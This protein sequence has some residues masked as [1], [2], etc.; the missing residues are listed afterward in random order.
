M[1]NTGQSFNRLVGR[2]F[3]AITAAAK[4]AKAPARR[5][6]TQPVKSL[7]GWYDGSGPKQGGTEMVTKRNSVS[8]VMLACLLAM[9][10][11]SLAQSPPAHPATDTSSLPE[12]GAARSALLRHLLGGLNEILLEPTEDRPPTMTDPLRLDEAVAL[13]LQNNFEIQAARARTEASEW[14]VVG[15]YGSYLPTVTYTRSNGKERSSPA[16][17]TE[18]SKR[19]EDSR[20]HRWDRSV[21]IVQPVIDLTLISDIL[22]RH[23]KLS[24]SELE[25]LGV[26][27]RVALQTAT[28]FLKI[29]RAD[30]SIRYA[31]D[32]KNHLDKLTT[33]MSNRV[34]G[35][36]AAGAD[37]D[38]VKSRATSAQAALIETRSDYDSALD[39]FR[40]LSGVV[41]LKLQMPAAL[42]PSV[43]E[44]MQDAMTRTLRSNPDYLL[45][46]QQIDV[47][48]QERD[49][50][51]SRMLP[52]LN[53]EYTKSRSW[54]AGGVALGLD[55]ASEEY[56][57][58]NNETKAML[59]ATWS[60]S[61]GT[62]IAEGL[63]AGA[64]AREANFKSLDT[65]GRLEESVRLAFNALNTANNRVPILERAL[66]SNARVVDAFEEQYISADRPLFDLLDAYD[67]RYKA[68]LDLTRVLISEAVAGYQL[69]SQMGEIVP[70]LKETEI[71]AH[72]A[73]PTP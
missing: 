70:A 16:S 59:T 53:F 48:F 38:R 33:V 12:R 20:H 54:N 43:P 63:A 25:Q 61:G 46:V 71:R 18:D 9:S 17:F 3:A 1:N 14:E 64:K 55:P 5:G 32:Y 19:V 10:S 34:E 24:A 22:L 13:A 62:E 28:A 51:Y 8:V 65:R 30:L 39:E 31:Q 21:R 36:G 6:T 58:Y 49:K 2:Y 44:S 41:P 37:L 67:R 29:V 7:A 45:S 11:P 40:R 72:P 15:A 68:Q 57:P 69:R 66:E 52:K 27:E 50:A 73:I 60:I 26:R 42:L 23:E 35:G 56:F 4:D 47:Q